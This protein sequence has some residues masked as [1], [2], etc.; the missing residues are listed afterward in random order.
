LNS[1]HQS[2][3]YSNP[4]I[5]FYL[6]LLTQIIDKAV[7]AWFKEKEVLPEKFLTSCKSFGLI[8]ALY[9]NGKQVYRHGTDIKLD[10]ST[11]RYIPE[12]IL[13]SFVIYER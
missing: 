4:N 3:L 9:H 10:L 11:N 12:Y 13:Y 1:K 8:T 6:E 2:I 5:F 7:I